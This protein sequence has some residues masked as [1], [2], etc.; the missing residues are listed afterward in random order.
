[1]F[2]VNFHQGNGIA[3]V[4]G[5]I[6][7]D[8]TEK[9]EVSQLEYKASQIETTVNGIDANVISIKT[10]T[11]MSS[12]PMTLAAKANYS[13]YDTPNQGEVYLHGLNDKRNPAD[14]DGKCIWNTKTVSLPKVMF[15]PNSIVPDGV[16]VY[17]V[18][19]I[20]DN[21]WWSVWKETNDSIIT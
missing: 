11:D 2:I 3:L 20:A 12:N 21:K 4:D 19:N 18:R 17:M 1:M 8:V 5:W 10:Y 14:I 7:E 13:A 16:P 6:L 9:I 15:N